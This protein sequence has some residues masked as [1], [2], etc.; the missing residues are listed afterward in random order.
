MLSPRCARSRSTHRR[1]RRKRFAR[2]RQ[3]M[4]HPPPSSESSCC[5]S[6]VARPPASARSSGVSSTYSQSRTVWTR[7]RARV[8]AR[9]SR[10]QVPFGRSRRRPTVCRGVRARTE[11][12]GPRARRARGLQDAGA[13]LCARLNVHGRLLSREGL[14]LL[15]RHLCTLWW[16]TQKECNGK[17]RGA[18]LQVAPPA[19]R[20]RPCCQR[21]AWPPPHSSHT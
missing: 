13:R 6:A 7:V 21:A 15:D 4:P 9:E 8:C 1:G 2:A 18:A 5:G 16:L 11:G 20:G 3:H 19:R 14:R 17:G 12:R 10:G